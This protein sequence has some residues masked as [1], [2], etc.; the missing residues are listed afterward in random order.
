MRLLLE[1]V[2]CAGFKSSTPRSL[3]TEAQ[4][5]A[6]CRGA[7]TLQG[8]GIAAAHVCTA[9]GAVVRAR[10]LLPVQ[11]HFH[12]PKSLRNF[13][14][15]LSPHNHAHVGSNTQVSLLFPCWLCHRHGHVLPGTFPRAH[16]PQSEQPGRRRARKEAI[17]IRN[18][19]E[20][21]A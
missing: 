21:S 18:L 6:L 11:P 4:T 2:P 16:S 1:W 15:T 19:C 14:I 9:K 8:R 3:G 17:A 7:S 5:G 10:V 12:V 13:L 20:K